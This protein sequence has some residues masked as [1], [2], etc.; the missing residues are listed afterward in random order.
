MESHSIQGHVAIETVVGLD[1]WAGGA[2]YCAGTFCTDY[3]VAYEIIQ[4]DA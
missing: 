3:D 2:R 1:L 4:T